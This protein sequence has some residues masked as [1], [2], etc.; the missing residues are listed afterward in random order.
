ML[1]GVLLF[2]CSE[3]NGGDLSLVSVL[4]GERQSL[5][6][7]WGGELNQ[8]T[9]AA[10]ELD[11]N[12]VHSGQA[13]YRADLGT[14]NPGEFKFFQTF[15]SKRTSNESIRQTRDLTRYD[16]LEAQI[17]NDTGSPFNLKLEIKDYRNDLGHQAFVNYAIPATT[18]WTKIDASLDLLQ[19]EWN[20][21]GSPDLSRSYVTSFVIT[22]SGGTVSGNIYVD[23]FKLSEP[24]GPVDIASAPLEQLVERLA[25]RQFQGLFDSRNRNSSLIYNSKNEVDR[26]AMNTT[27]GTL[28]MLP[29]AVERGWVSQAEADGYATQLV[30]TLNANLDQTSYLPTRFLDPSNGDLPGGDNEESSIDASFLALALHRYKSAP[31]TSVA[32][33]TAMDLVQNRFNLDAF[34]NSAGFQLAY[35]PATGFSGN[36]YNGYTNEGKVIS[37]AAE[38]STSHHV[39]LEQHW[40]ADTNRARAFLVDPTNAH[41]V[42]SS[43]NFRAPFEQ[44]LLNLFVETANLGV[45]NFPNRTLA[46][47]PWHNYLRYE[48]EVSDK[49]ELLGRDHFFQPDAASGA[50]FSSYQQYS[51]YNDFGQPDLFMPWSTSLALLAGAE[52]AESALRALLDVDGIAGPLGLADSVRWDPNDTSPYFISDSGDNWNTVLSTMALL[53]LLDNLHSTPSASDQ[54]AALGE[55]TGALANVFVDGDLSGDGTTNGL[56]LQIWE[57]GYGQSSGATPAEGDADGDADVD[58]LDFLRWQ[59]G[60]QSGNSPLTTVPESSSGALFLLGIFYLLKFRIKLEI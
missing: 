29:K 4:D 9:V 46:T 52:G 7:N 34:T 18:G 47:N 56:D 38:L 8:A 53:E 32:L 60:F 3:V 11:T 42:H 44:A 24:G 12:I 1:A 28:W 25:R 50:P 41:L 49:L 17:Y 21:I 23:E 31:G 36:T 57:A 14:L 15:S 26:A 51:L 33:G 35:L 27:G 5:L 30:S 16:G 6:N 58:G 48:Q 55:V 40:N 2:G 43:S 10:L 45:D 22:P 59:M 20:T 19:P 54:F 13:S 39:P 37:L